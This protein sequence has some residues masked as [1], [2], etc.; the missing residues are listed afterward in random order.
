MNT[1]KMKDH[2]NK[3][4]KEFADL[5]PLAILALTIILIYILKLIFL[6]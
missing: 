5:F 3:F 2:N 4:F 1:L 6:N